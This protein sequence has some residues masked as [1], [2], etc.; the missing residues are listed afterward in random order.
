MRKLVLILLL[1]S[2]SAGGFPLGL[3]NIE[4]IS[5]L[6]QSF[7]ARIE[8]LSPTSSELDS[9]NIRVADIE[10]FDRAGIEWLIILNSLSFEVEINDSGPDY[11]KI[12]SREAIREPFLNFLLEASWSSGRLFREYTVLLDPPFYDPGERQITT[13]TVP[14]SNTSP[15]SSISTSSGQVS[16]SVTQSGSISSY[17]GDEYGPVT[18]N[19]TLWAIANQVRPD[20]SISVQQMMLALL[21]ANPEAFIGGNIN[22]LRQ[23]Q[24]L[25]VPNQNEILNISLDEAIADVSSQNA[26][27]E[28]IRG[29]F[30]GNA[31][32]RPIGTSAQPSSDVSS[33]TVTPDS[34]LRLVT[35]GSQS[36]GIG[37]SDV[38]SDSA[39]QGSAGNILANEQLEAM[40]SENNDL[41]NRLEESEALIQDLRRLIELKDDELATIQ[42]Q[43][44]EGEDQTE[45]LIMGEDDQIVSDEEIDIVETE[46][47][48][49]ELVDEAIT[50]LELTG[51]SD[52]TTLPEPIESTSEAEIP[53]AMST[54]T[55][56]TMAT[57]AGLV[58][59]ILRFIFGNMMLLG[60]A[61]GAVILGVLGFLFIR[62]R[63]GES[64][65]GSDTAAVT[66]FPDFESTADATDMPESLSEM[67]VEADVEDEDKDALIG[68]VGADQLSNEIAETPEV[69]TSAAEEPEDDPL[70]EV[71]VFLAYEHFDQAEEFVRDAIT[72]SPENLDFHSKLLEV[73][74]SSGDKVKYEEEAKVVNDL[75]N[76]EGPHWEM[77]QIMWQ[78]ISPNRAL[79]AEPTDGEVDEG[80]AGD[81]KTGGIVD[82]TAD[83]DVDEDDDS[84][85]F[86]LGMS[87]AED[88]AT[89][90][91]N[92]SDDVLD[93]T[94]G[95]DD[96]LDIT[97]DVAAN[98]EEDLLDVTAAVGLDA[99]EEVKP[100]DE[101]DFLDISTTHDG[102]EDLLDVTAHSDLDA[103]DGEDLL[104][105]TSASDLSSVEGESISSLGNDDPA[106]ADDNALDF[107]IGGL[108]VD[109]T[110]S[111]E[112][113]ETSDENVSDENI[114]DFDTSTSVSTE[115][116]S[117]IAL[118]LGVDSGADDDSGGIELD[119]GV[120]SGEDDGLEISLD[121]ADDD[122]GGI[123]LD[124]GSDTEENDGMEI[125]L[126]EGGD[127]GIE[128]DMA[129]EDEPFASDISLD[130]DIEE[131]ASV[132]EIEMDSTVK[133]PNEISFDLDSNDDD[134]DDDDEDHA[135]FVPRTSDAS[136][137]S[138]EDEV[139]TK[140]D[141]AKAYVELGDT[142]S[143]S[144]ILDEIIAEGNDAQRQQAE[145]LKSQLS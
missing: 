83:D 34:E 85:D 87:S 119:L 105:V 115:E 82:L 96:V 93:I 9:L 94:S 73:F 6:N 41:I 42:Q 141:L 53:P 23:G 24:I 125:S 122:T 27:W 33:S 29:S 143:A 26:I 58:D 104:D 3:G 127:V 123:E 79:F 140:L 98:S 114:I 63:K 75:V 131:E 70:A 66:D 136:E 107:D 132:L 17:S 59:Q 28:D 121:G 8:L 12:S 130:M 40:S 139:A 109:S 133:I 84:L 129:I 90:E 45:E 47:D 7:D 38:T 101:E 60:G 135:V 126:D 72:N 117:G 81:A 102:E 1:M 25:R 128:L 13:P 95:S 49:I 74:Y 142:G 43:V 39:G 111:D 69:E 64:V 145:Q 100:A 11:I 71:N 36:S 14:S 134:D 19:D 2:V 44:V 97:S 108:D 56:E 65:E 50:S 77:A 57:D 88:A 21:R 51:T 118:D 110:N 91:N 68:E 35:P 106:I 31:V 67:D 124:L 99:I 46:D 5:G 30:A 37:Q 116:D 48:Q 103:D 54:T 52:E 62:K 76:G 137:Q 15:E 61:I 4:L 86:D 20:S 92:N 120:D 32:Q 138:V 18:S 55:T 80:D 144:T 89:N 112:V 22:G 113:N 78:E 16:S 10:A